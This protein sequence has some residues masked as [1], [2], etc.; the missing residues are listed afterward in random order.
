[1]RVDRNAAAVVGDGDKAIRLHFDLDPVGVAGERFVHGIVD[2]LGEQVMQRLLVGA[3]DI[4]AGPAAHR[5]EPF[6]NLYMARGIG[7]FCRGAAQGGA[8]GARNAARCRSRFAQIGEQV[9]CFRRRFRCF[10]HAKF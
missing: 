6:Q 1:M 2:H 4:H 3:A 10:S 7:R 5:F 8:A 9:R